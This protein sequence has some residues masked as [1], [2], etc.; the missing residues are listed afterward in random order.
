MEVVDCAY[1]KKNFLSL[2]DVQHHIDPQVTWLSEATL[3]P[4]DAAKMKPKLSIGNT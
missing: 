3:D 2:I 4:V 1:I